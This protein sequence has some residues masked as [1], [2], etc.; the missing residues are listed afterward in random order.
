VLKAVSQYG[1]RNVRVFGSVARGEDRE[2]SDID[3][4]IDFAP[5]TS[6]LTLAALERE[7]AKLLGT[8]VDVVPADSIKPRV[9]A[10]AAKDSVD[11]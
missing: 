5:G 9:Y 7:L 8:H 4:L 10:A 11:L 6:L 3:L 2:D 1:G